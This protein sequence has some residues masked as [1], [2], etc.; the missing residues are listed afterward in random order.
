MFFREFPSYVELMTQTYIF[1][2]VGL[3]REVQQHDSVVV[4]VGSILT[5]SGMPYTSR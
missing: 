1:S 3:F 5:A 4:C 2:Y